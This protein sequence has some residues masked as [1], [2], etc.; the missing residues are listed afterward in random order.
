[1]IV[2]P[3]REQRRFQRPH[4]R[5]RLR[6]GPRVQIYSPRRNRSFLQDSSILRL[7]TEAD[8]LLMDV[9]SDIVDSVHWVLLIWFLSRPTAGLSSIFAQPSGGPH[10]LF[11]QTG[12]NSED[13]K[14]INRCADE[15]RAVPEGKPFGTACHKKLALWN[16]LFN[17]ARLFARLRS[18]LEKLC[19]NHLVTELT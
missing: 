16:C 5:P 11:I 18:T 1:M 2:D 17:K 10:H 3:A 12:G 7:G 8:S 9:E 6:L 13:R 4:P 15:S 19:R 14:G